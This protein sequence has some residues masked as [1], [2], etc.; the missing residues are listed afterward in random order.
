MD[1]QFRFNAWGG[2][3]SEQSPKNINKRPDALACEHVLLPLECHIRRYI[4]YLR[5][6][7]KGRG[8]GL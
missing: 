2:R 3:N 8:R 6:A 7:A 1:N 4:L 5:T